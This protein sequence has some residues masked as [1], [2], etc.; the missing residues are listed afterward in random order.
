PRL[1][2]LTENL[3]QYIR[4]H[5]NEELDISFG[6]TVAINTEIGAMIVDG[7]VWSLSL[8]VIIIVFCYMIFFRSIGAGLLAAVPL[9]CAIVLVFGLMGVFNI[10]L[11]YITATLTGISIG[12]GTD[13]TA[14]FLWRLRERASV[15]GNLEQGYLETMTTIGKGIVYNG[16]SVVVGFFVFLLSNF[17]PIRFFGFL[18]SFSI[19]ACIVSTLTILPIVIFFV[20][21]EFLMQGTPTQGEKLEVP[22]GLL[23]LKPQAESVTIR[24]YNER[25]HVER[26]FLNEQ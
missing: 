21:P 18:V 14:Y 11:D 22:L 19:L 10:P 5:P 2:V 12:A 23:P 6:G 1:K 15:C 17:I 7:Q 8:S 20:K 24:P 13:Y 16:L 26:E 4:D 25:N 3:K 9:F